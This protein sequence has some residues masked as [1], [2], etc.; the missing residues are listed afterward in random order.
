[1]TQMNLSAKEK[2]TH[3]HREQTWGCQ[4]GGKVGEGYVGSLGLADANYIYIEREWI[5]KV[6]LYSTGN[7]IQYPVINYNGKN[8]KKNVRICLTESLCCTAEINTTL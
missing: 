5:N 7:Y 6:Q 4:G 1:M 8:M 3:R 2:Q